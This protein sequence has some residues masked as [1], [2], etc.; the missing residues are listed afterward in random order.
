MESGFKDLNKDTES[1]EGCLMILTQVNG[2]NQKLMGKVSTLGKMENVMK[3]SGT[4]LLNKV[5][6]LIF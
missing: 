6:E 1:G 3:V 2:S 5:Q 4:W